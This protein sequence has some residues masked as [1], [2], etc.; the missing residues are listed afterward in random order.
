MV[1][2]HDAE[3]S[4]EHLLHSNEKSSKTSGNGSQEIDLANLELLLVLVENVI[5]LDL[6]EVIT[7]L[8]EI[9][10]LGQV[11]ILVVLVALFHLQGHFFENNSHLLK[12]RNH[13]FVNLLVLDEGK[14]H[15]VNGIVH[16]VQEVF[17]K[18]ST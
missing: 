5:R 1:A 6:R 10:N 11:N 2:H 16:L 12:G 18:A 17:V 14:E 4:P 9:V 15:F 13:V 8:K 7:H 3:V